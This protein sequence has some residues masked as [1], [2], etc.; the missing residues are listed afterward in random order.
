MHLRPGRTDVVVVRETFIGLHHVAPPQL[1]VASIK[2]ILDLGANIGL[3]AAHAAVLHPEA[4]IL[5]VELDRDNADL[6]A[7]NVEA[8][9]A[10]CEVLHGA[11]WSASGTIRYDAIPGNDYGLRWSVDGQLSTRAFTL[12]ELLD[13]LAP[14]GGCVDYVKMDVEGAEEQVLESST[15]WA[16]RVRAIKVEVHEP[17]SVERCAR[18]L[19]EVGYETS[20]DEGHHAC[21][22]GI[23]PAPD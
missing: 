15:S 22:V 11:V 17:Y 16:P 10:R 21:V 8:F 7:Q 2:T 20:V 9:G 12:D 4:T 18:R 6:A 5:A 1:P 14:H 19:A 13:R 23:R 3:T